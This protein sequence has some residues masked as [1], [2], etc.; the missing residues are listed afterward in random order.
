MSGIDFRAYD[1]KQ[2]CS[3]LRK[4]R[5]RSPLVHLQGAAG[6]ERA[7]NTARTIG[8][9]QQLT[10]SL[11]GPKDIPVVPYSLYRQYQRSG[12]RTEH[13]SAV[14][15]R[16]IACRNQCLAVWLDHPQADRDY[17][18]DLIWAVC[19]QHTWLMPAHEQ[20][21]IELGSVALMLLLAEMMHLMGEHLDAEVVE[22]VHQCIQ[23]RGLRRYYASANTD[24][25]HTSSNNWNLVCNGG[26]IRL[27]LLELHEP[28]EQ[29]NLIHRALNN[30]T[31]ALEGF[32]DDGGCDEGHGYWAY[33]FGEFALAA[34]AL[35][36]KTNG[37]LNIMHFPKIKQICAFPL[38]IHV[39]DDVF[40]PYSDSHPHYMNCLLPLLINQFHHIPELYQLCR[41][42]ARGLLRVNNPQMNHL[43]HIL[44]LYDGHPI[45]GKRQGADSLLPDLRLAKCCSRPGRDQTTVL[46]FAAHN[47]LSHNHNDT[48]N[49]CLFRHGRFYLDDPGAPVYT[50]ATFSEQRY[51]SLFC[52]AYGHNIPII[53]GQEQIA[54]AQYRGTLS[55]DG[56]DTRTQKSMEMQLA[57]AYPKGTVEEFQRRIELDYQTHACLWRDRFVFARKPKALIENFVT[58]LPVHVA[59]DQR[60]VMIGSG[61]KSITLRAET[62][63]HF[64]CLVCNE[65]SQAGRSGRILTRIL[66]EPAQLAKRMEVCFQV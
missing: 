48:G 57:A 17:A 7:Q 53:N 46:A 12:S 20:C 56:F 55:V 39:Q 21:Q 35:L 45:K 66:F 11:S 58:F 15:K 59:D 2:L 28:Q 19:D 18:Q 52:N 50:R 34:L 32:S 40:A 27:A 8:F 3:I 25:W 10:K 49:V 47:G 64:T 43:H 30:M 41:R 29:A 63:G 31:Y 60:S 54:G 44:G 24:S 42:N 14:N 33:G 1:L 4:N 16:Y 22:R 61:N 23:E 65:E 38:A 37:S 6:R 5:K 9:W 51:D 13:E 62:A 36:H 26:M